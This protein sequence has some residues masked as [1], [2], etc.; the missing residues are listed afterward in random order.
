MSTSPNNT[1]PLNVI[2]ILVDSVRNYKSGGDDRD[3]LDIMEKIGP[4]CIDFETVVTSAPSSLMSFSAMM[5][6]SHQALM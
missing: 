2:W 3:K 1:A 4:Q 5:T 6:Q